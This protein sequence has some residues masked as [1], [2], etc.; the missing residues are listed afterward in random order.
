MRLPVSLE[1]REAVVCVRGRDRVQVR[2]RVSI[3]IFLHLVRVRGG[4]YDGR[5]AVGLHAAL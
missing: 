3:A 4:S 2:W 1:L 5:E